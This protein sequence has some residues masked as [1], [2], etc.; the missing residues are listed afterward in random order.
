M[1]VGAGAAILDHKLEATCEGCQSD[2]MEGAR[3]SDTVG[4]QISLDRLPSTG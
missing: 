4:F 1:V 3:V 2:K